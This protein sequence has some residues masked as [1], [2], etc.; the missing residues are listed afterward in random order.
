VPRSDGE[1]GGWWQGSRS[2][3]EWFYIPDQSTAQA[4]LSASEL[5]HFERPHLDLMP[6][7]ESDPNITV[8]F[9]DPLGNQSWLRP[10]HL[11]PPF[12][13]VKAR[14]ALLWMVNQADY[15]RAVAGD[16]KFWRTCAAYF[17]CG[18]PLETDA[19]AP[20]LTQNLDKAR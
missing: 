5:D 19:G 3:G 17:M 15:M 14:Q 9:T 18:T 8:A 7:L 11:H 16:P 10:N 20:G 12:N 1:P 4:A 2:I 13:N 6:L